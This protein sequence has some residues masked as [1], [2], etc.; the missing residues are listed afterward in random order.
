MSK[1]SRIAGFYRLSP[2]ERLRVVK[3]FADLSD[4]EAEIL[5]STGALG[6]EQANRMIENVVGTVELPLGI[7]VNFLINGRDYLV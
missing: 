3:E 6:L 1:S 4:E 5:R 2:E 7:A